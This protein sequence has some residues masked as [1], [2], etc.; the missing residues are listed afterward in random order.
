MTLLTNFTAASGHVGRTLKIGQLLTN[1]M[2]RVNSTYLARDGQEPAVIPPYRVP[3]MG[4]GIIMHPDSF[5][6]FGA[7]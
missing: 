1:L 3:H 4:C 5:V 2:A 6:D 7:I